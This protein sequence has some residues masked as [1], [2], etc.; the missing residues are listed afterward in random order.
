MTNSGPSTPTSLSDIPLQE[1]VS[2]YYRAK[3]EYECLYTWREHWFYPSIDSRLS[4]LALIML[5]IQEEIERRGEIPPWKKGEKHERVAIE[6]SDG[7]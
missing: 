4:I 6:D 1:L 2:A 5:G 7:C 3:I